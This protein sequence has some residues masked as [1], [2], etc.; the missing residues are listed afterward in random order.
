MQEFS[1]ESITFVS[2]CLLSF[3]FPLSLSIIF[4]LW[5][6]FRNCVWMLQQMFQVLYLILLMAQDEESRIL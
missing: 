5:K 3:S 1:N 4:P 6:W 2:V